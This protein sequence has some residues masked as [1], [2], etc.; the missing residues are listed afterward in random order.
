MQATCKIACS[1]LDI[2]ELSTQVY[3]G[4]LANGDTVFLAIN[5]SPFDRAGLQVNL[6]EIGLSS[7]DTFVARDLWKHADGQSFSGSFDTGAIP[8]YGTQVFRLRKAAQ[9]Q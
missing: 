3:S 9:T 7:T 4:P 5:W 6:S 1:Y 8:A 2:L